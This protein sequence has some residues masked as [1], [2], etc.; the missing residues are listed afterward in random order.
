MS[1]SVDTGAGENKTLQGID[2]QQVYPQT[3]GV[4]RRA[5]HSAVFEAGWSSEELMTRHRQISRWA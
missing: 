2:A 4:S 1:I 5:M 3:E